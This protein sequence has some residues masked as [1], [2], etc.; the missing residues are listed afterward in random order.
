MVGAGVGTPAVAAT[1]PPTVGFAFVGD[2]I[3]GNTPQLPANPD[4]YV[5]PVVTSLRSHSDVVFA[6]LEGTLTSGGTSKCTGGSG[7]TCYAFRNPPSYAHVFAHAGV[8]VLNLANNHSYDYGADGLRATRRAIADARMHYTGLPGQIT[9]LNVHSTRIA[10]V[11]FAPYARTNNLLDLAQAARLIRRAH[12]HAAIVVVYMHAGAEGAAADHVTGREEHFAG[13]DRGNPQR[14][15]H[16]AIDNGAGLV[17]AS[18]PHALRG[19]EFYRHRLIDYS[20]GDFVNYRNF[21]SSGTLSRSLILHV[22][23]TTRGAFGSA[24]LTSVRLDRGGRASIGGDAMGFVAK[25]S[26]QDFAEHA[27]RI[28]RT[29]RISDP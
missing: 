8:A 12:A 3:L 9:Y 7:G 18:G 17:V 21:S 15:A 6:N 28:S 20:L 11:A 2:T 29:G 26:R 5:A 13:E 27:A 1:P 14:F 22:T 24:Q 19:L 23:L 4:R 25:L 10:F 16:M